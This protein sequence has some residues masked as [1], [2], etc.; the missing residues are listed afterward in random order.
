MKRFRKVSAAVLLVASVAVVGACTVSTGTVGKSGGG[1]YATQHS[2]G[3]S[4][5]GDF[6]P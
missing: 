3:F 4:R 1:A 5:G 2:S 6:T